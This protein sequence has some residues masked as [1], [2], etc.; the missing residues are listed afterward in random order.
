MI[1]F[2]KIKNKDG[3]VSVHT[4]NS[5]FSEPVIVRLRENCIIFTK[6]TIDYQGKTHK[7]TFDKISQYL[8]TQLKID[9]KLGTYEFDE[10]S[11]EDKMIIY[12]D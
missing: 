3:Y 4:K 5:F 11:N 12:F 2:S 7:F 8:R 10:E 1:T 9:V 6:P